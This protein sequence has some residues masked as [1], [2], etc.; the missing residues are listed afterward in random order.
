[1]LCATDRNE[2]EVEVA[3]N[4]DMGTLFPYLQKKKLNLVETSKRL[5]AAFYLNSMVSITLLS[6]EVDCLYA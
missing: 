6:K 5:S 3:L 1:M 2:V 4:Q